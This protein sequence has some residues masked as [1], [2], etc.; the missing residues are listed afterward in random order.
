MMPFPTVAAFTS[1]WTPCLLAA[2]LLALL[3]TY[4][5][6]RCVSVYNW[7]A[8]HML[9]ISVCATRIL[10]L[11][12]IRYTVYYTLPLQLCLPSLPVLQAAWHPGALP[13]P[14]HRQPASGEGGLRARSTCSARVYA[15]T[16]ALVLNFCCRSTSV[17]S[18]HSSAG[19][20]ETSVGRCAR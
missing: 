17:T 16:F 14:L 7:T 13:A 12:C 6:Y 4:L 1:D 18:T 10:L 2:T 9:G 20:M 11:L 8:V 15:R 19:S 3:L 5:W